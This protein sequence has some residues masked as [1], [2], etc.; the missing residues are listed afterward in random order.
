MRRWFRPLLAYLAAA[1]VT[2]WPLVL[3]PASLLGAPSGPGDPFLNL[4]ILGW[5]MQ[6]VIGNPASLLDGRVFNANIFHPAAGT[7]AYS[8]HLLLQSVLLAPL[9]AITHD[10]VLCYNVL[11]I[12]SLVASA[13]A[14]HLFVRGVVGTEGGAYLAGLAWGFGSYHFAHLIHL[15]LQSLYFLP[16]AFLFLHRVIAGRRRRDVIWLGV[17]AGLQALSSV[18]YGII[19]GL[20]LVVGAIILAIGVGRWRSAAVARRLVAAA[21]LAALLVAP[22]ALVYWRVG[23]REGFGR[24]LYEAGR[25][26]AYVSSYLQV[27]PGNVVYG[28][29]DLLRQ[30]DI[31]GSTEPPH[32]GPERELFPGF[33]LV[34]LAIAG[35]WLGW[36]RDGRPTVLS[37]IAIAALGF[38]LSLGPDGIRPLYAAFHRFVFGFQAIRAPARFSVLVLFG[39]CTLAAI[40]WR[41]LSSPRGPQRRRISHKAH[42]EHDVQKHNVLGVLRGR[43]VFV[44]FVAAVLEWLH[45]PLSLAPAPPLQTD[46]GQWLKRAPEPGAVAIL[47]LDLDIASTP[48][49]VQSLE[50]RRPIVNGY[51]GQRPSFYGP[52]VEALN[53]FPSADSL[54]ALRDSGVRFVVTPAPIAP[55]AP[56]APL[57]P[58]VERARFKDTTIYELRWTP[59]IEARLAATSTVEPPPAGPIPFHVGEVARYRVGWGGAGM[60]LSAGDISISVEPPAYRLV[61]KAVTAPWVAKFFEARD[62][63]ATQSDAALLPQVHERDQQEGSRHVARAFVY[64]HAARVVRTGGSVAEARADGAVVLPMVPRARDAIAALFYARTLPLREGEHYRFPVNEAGRN[65]IVE[66]TVDGREMIRVQGRGVD[67]WRLTPRLQRRVEAREQLAAI[68]WLSTDARRVPLALD[69]DAGFGHVRVELESYQEGP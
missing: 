23:Q 36:R 31:A 56:L 11:L 12:A 4:W 63:F 39:L 61:V 52:L 49:M 3:H 17:T 32:T 46:V 62:V 67:A 51:S 6:A 53:A 22:V 18:Y 42:K 20:A 66:L 2:T 43:F 60:S 10:V 58:I 19:G 9:Y 33:V 48:A 21:A 50:H 27:P 41:E 34:A 69:L 8:D 24:N 44:I 68:V 59:D 1:V 14:M 38:V 57:E 25:N 40:G 55:L 29:T 26:A 13:M 65:L 37:M 35:A 15:Q 47:P 5:D 28:R 64:D 16:L 30:R 54:L 45:V 7:L